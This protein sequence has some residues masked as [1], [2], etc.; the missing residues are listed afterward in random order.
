[1]LI[2]KRSAGEGLDGAGLNQLAVIG[3][4]PAELLLIKASV[5]ATEHKDRIQSGLSCLGLLPAIAG[6]DSVW[7][8]SCDRIAVQLDAGPTQAT[9]TPVIVKHFG[10]GTTEVSALLDSGEGPPLDGAHC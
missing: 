6:F 2:V 3:A 5:V 9:I 8:N 10:V 4:I 7:I 1:M